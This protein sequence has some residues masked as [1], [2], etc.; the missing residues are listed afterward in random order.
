MDGIA[1]RPNAK[2]QTPIS[3]A[4]SNIRPKE[5]AGGD[6][7]GHRSA[8]RQSDGNSYAQLLQDYDSLN[9]KGESKTKSDL[10]PKFKVRRADGHA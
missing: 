7:S 9:K 2:Q 10:P 6:L 4:K 5:G 1:P 8:E 3:R